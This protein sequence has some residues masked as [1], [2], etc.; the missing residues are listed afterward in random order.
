M[1]LTH[2]TVQPGRRWLSRQDAPRVVEI[3]EQATR[4]REPIVWI[5]TVVP[6]PSGST[7]RVIAVLLTTLRRRFT[8]LPLN[9]PN[10]SDPR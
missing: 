4:N 3:V 10:G 9:D 6:G 1:D 5:R 2:P 7:G 8:V